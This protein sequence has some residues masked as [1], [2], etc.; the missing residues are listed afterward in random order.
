MT[1]WMKVTRDKFELPLAV[2]DT[3]EELAKMLGL[4][5]INFHGGRSSYIKIECPDEGEQDDY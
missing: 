3:K 1:L 2:A 4:K 5:R